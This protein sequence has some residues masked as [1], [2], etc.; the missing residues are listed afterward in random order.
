MCIAAGCTAFLTK[1]I[2][3]G[4]LLQAIKDRSVFA[5]LAAKDEGARRETF[6][7]RANPRFADLIP[8]FLHNR[9]QDVTAMLEA[10]K[11]GDF[12]TVQ[13][14][15]HDMK[16]VGGSYGFPTITDIGAAL[17]QSA[18]SSDTGT[19]RMWTGELARYL[20]GVEVVS[21]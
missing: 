11:H 21:E 4:T 8:G 18:A 7:V 16:G 9:R 1:P 15:G 5:T 19:A 10:L 13:R 17:E 14:L 6:Q 2:N 12:Q 3:Q 20:D